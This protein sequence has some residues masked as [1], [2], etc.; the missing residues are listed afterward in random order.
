MQIIS[1]MFAWFAKQAHTQ[2]SFFAQKG[3]ELKATKET[4][5][6][7]RALTGEGENL[8]SVCSLSQQAA[9]DHQL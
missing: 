7:F 9:R 5:R 6:L 2:G 1:R 4:E 8:E 3:E